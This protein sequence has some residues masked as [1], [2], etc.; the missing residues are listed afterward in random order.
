MK[1]QKDRCQEFFVRKFQNHGN[2]VY[3]RCLKYALRLCFIVSVLSVS[4][5]LLCF[6]IGKYS[7][8]WYSRFPL[9]EILQKL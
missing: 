9:N 3:E 7:S 5:E 6:E 1:S 8:R 4:K 2:F